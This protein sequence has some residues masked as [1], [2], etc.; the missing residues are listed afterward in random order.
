MEARHIVGI[1]LFAILGT[2]VLVFFGL[3]SFD[4]PPAH[5]EAINSLVIDW[6]ATKP[7]I[8]KEQLW[9]AECDAYEKQEAEG[10]ATYSLLVVRSPHGI[11]MRMDCRGNI[12]WPHGQELGAMYLAMGLMENW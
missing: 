11:V 8:I 12:E 9:L 4:A 1:F 6:S 2:G 7:D 10:G 5:H 3:M